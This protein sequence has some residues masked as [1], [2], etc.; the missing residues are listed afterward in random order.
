MK[1]TL[2][3]V[4]DSKLAVERM[5]ALSP[6]PTVKVAYKMARNGRALN[7][8]MRDSSEAIERVRADYMKAVIG[9][10]GEARME[11]PPEREDDLEVEIDEM[12]AQ[13]VD[14]DIRV[15]TEEEL[16]ACEDK[17]PGFDLSPVILYAAPFMFGLEGDDE[18]P[19]DES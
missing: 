16:L 14:V 1:L 8:V 15:I 4:Y 13:T 18:E 2:K 17:R 6:A 19:A 3:Q 9:E 5:L 10:D 7:A 11:I 12:L